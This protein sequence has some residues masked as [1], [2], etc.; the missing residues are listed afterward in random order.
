MSGVHLE[1]TWKKIVLGVAALVLVPIGAVKGCSFYTDVRLR[2]EAPKICVVPE[3]R[4]NGE[5]YLRGRVAVVN[6]DKQWDWLIADYM[7]DGLAA[8]RP[9]EISTC[10]VL[11]WDWK[12]AGVYDVTTTHTRGGQSYKTEGRE[13][14]KAQTCHALVVDLTIPAVVA[15]ASFVGRVRDGYVSDGTGDRDMSMGDKPVAELEKWLYGLPRQ[16]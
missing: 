6:Q 8:R 3:A 16:P 4:V 13:L 1:V 14:A 11:D 10:V 7:P 12:A 9:E 2:R 5:G 15:E